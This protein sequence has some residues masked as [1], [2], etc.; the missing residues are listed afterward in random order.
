[1]KMYRGLRKPVQA[2][3]TILVASDNFTP[4]TGCSKAY[5]QWLQQ[6]RARSNCCHL[7][8]HV[9][10]YE[11]RQ[12]QASVR[13]MKSG[14]CPKQSSF[15]SAAPHFLARQEAAVT[16]SLHVLCHFQWI[17]QLDAHISYGALQS[18]DF[19]I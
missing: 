12:R 14:A 9:L 4:R 17:I 1:M 6:G 2:R 19:R 13:N 15:P 18:M 16:S 3:A 10:S 11:S 8:L 5:D 7:V